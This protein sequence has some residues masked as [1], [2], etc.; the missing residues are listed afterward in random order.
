MDTKKH[1][2]VAGNIGA[3]K[4]TLVEE[5]SRA[6]GYVP[7]FEP[8]QE[9]PY[10]EDFYRDMP[11]WAFHSQIYFLTHRVQSH[12]V[13]AQQPRPVVQDRSVY[14]DALV[15]A[16]NL[17]LG[18]MMTDRDWKTYEGLYQTVTQLLPPP[19]LVVYIRASVAT[20][21]R[22]IAKRGRS[23]EEGL[24]PQYLA[25][26]NDLY[27]QWIGG[28]SLAPVMVI[29]GDEVDF[30]EDSRAMTPILGEVRQRL[31][32]SQGLLFGEEGR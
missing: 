27:E 23:F 9:N 28:F 1:I 3:G 2:I 13:L 17:F 4:S 11:R 24:D 5:L 15:F 22:R 30:V 26:L 25:G 18:G 7:Y 14:E 16:R 20:L 29:E 32:G 8:V 19:D 10:L 21:E 6:L 31:A 12:H